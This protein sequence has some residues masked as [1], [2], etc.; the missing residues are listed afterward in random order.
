[1]PGNVDVERTLSHFVIYRQ[2]F[3]YTFRLIDKCSGMVAA[4]AA[5]ATKFYA[6]L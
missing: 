6:V 3:G 2:L 1:M 4:A 5:A